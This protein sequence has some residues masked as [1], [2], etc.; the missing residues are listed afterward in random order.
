LNE[1]TLAS[2]DPVEGLT[3]FNVNYNVS[4][5]DQVYLPVAME[6]MV[7]ADKNNRTNTPGYLGT[8]LEVK[9]V[10]K[11]LMDFTGA[12]G[13]VHDPKNPKNWPIYTVQKDGSGGLL[14]PDAGIRVPGANNVFQFLAQPE[15]NVTPSKLTPSP[16]C[17]APDCI[18][19]MSNGPVW[20]GTKFVDG[21]IMQW[22]TCTLFPTK[23]NCP[24]SGLYLAVN[25]AFQTNYKD[26]YAECGKSFPTWLAPVGN[27]IPPLPN[28]YAFLQFVYGWVPFN[29]VCG[30]IE[31]PT[32]PTPREYI[33]L[34]DNF[35]KIRGTPAA[36]GEK[37]FNRY[38]Q[39]IHGAPDGTP[40]VHFGLDAA[41]YAYSIDDQSSFL[42]KPGVGLIFAVG[43]EVGLP[44]PDQ[45]IFPTPLDPAHDIQV[46][47]GGPI[48]TAPG[49]VAYDLCVDPTVAAVPGRSFTIPSPTDADGGQR[50]SVPTDIP[51]IWHVPCY[52][53]ILDSANKIYQ[54]EVLQTLDKKLNTWAQFNSPENNGG[55][56]LSVMACP[57]PKVPA[58]YT[59]VMGTQTTTPRS[60]ETTGAAPPTK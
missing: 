16:R 34:S 43:K 24:Q 30:G 47:L 27:S 14:Y 5:V 18:P 36:E 10:R 56:D 35:Q 20:S 17:A 4:N 28:L 60:I 11:R 55:F 58:N 2:V 49:W 54:I 42:S 50:F 44:N 45:F 23:E 41:A 1:Y 29:V 21:M 7:N 59:A 40:K 37:I 26:L 53:T 15:I 25:S 6:P 22:M 12:T 51:A 39:L 19:T 52:L 8:T 9:V 3:N 38:A 48:G 13:D 57:T 32:G 33:M 46:I 31:L